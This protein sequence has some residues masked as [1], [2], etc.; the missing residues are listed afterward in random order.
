M[1]FIENN[2]LYVS[3][4]KVSFSY[5]ECPFMKIEYQ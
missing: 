1:R 2:I 5:R 3:V 4:N